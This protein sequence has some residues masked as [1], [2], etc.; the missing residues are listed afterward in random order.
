[1][2]VNMDSSMVGDPRFRIIARKLNVSIREVFGACFLLWLAC[3]ERRSERLKPIEANASTDLDGFLEALIE[4]GLAHAD[5]EWICIHGV[6]DRIR[7]LFAQAKKGKKGGKNSVKSRRLKHMLPETLSIDKVP[8]QAE[9][10]PPDLALALAPALAPP[11]DQDQVLLPG[12]IGETNASPGIAP[13]QQAPLQPPS[14]NPRERDCFQAVQADPT[15]SQIVRNP[16]LLAQDLAKIAPGVNLSQEVAKAGAWLRANPKNMKRNGARF[17][18]NWLSRAQDKGGH[19]NG[20]YGPAPAKVER[21]GL[22]VNEYRRQMEGAS[23]RGNAPTPAQ[24][25]RSAPAGGS[26]GGGPVQGSLLSL[27]A[28]EPT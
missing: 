13:R 14:L 24:G 7:F 26:G 3:Y 15:L 27:K 28:K 20:S 22:D 2:R 9:L 17:L 11:P 25:G 5:D 6:R 21:R 12:A 1:M 16:A 23:V 19:G 8:A 18:T 10:K 4:V